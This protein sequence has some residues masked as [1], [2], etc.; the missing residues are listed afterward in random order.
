MSKVSELELGEQA[1]TKVERE[2]ND[3]NA[4]ILTRIIRGGQKALQAAVE[5]GVAAGRFG[6]EDDERLF[7]YIVKFAGKH[8]EPPTMETVN[9]KF[10][11]FMQGDTNEPTSVVLENWQQNYTRWST[12]TYMKQH[13]LPALDRG[14]APAELAEIMQR[15]AD[16]LRSLGQM[17]G[18]AEFIHGTEVEAE[19][20]RWLW[21][22]WIP[23]KS[24]TV[25]AA[26]PKVGKGFWTVWVAAQLTRGWRGWEKRNVGFLGHEDSR[27]ILKARLEASGADPAR[28]GFLRGRDNAVLT[29]PKDADTIRHQIEEHE[30]G[31]LFIDPI[32]NH[33]DDDINEN[34]DKEL[35]R[36][37]S[38]LALIAQETGCI[39]IVVHHFN[40]GS[41]NSKLL[42]RYSGAMAISGVSRS[43]LALGRKE[44]DASKDASKDPDGPEEIENESHVRWLFQTG[45]NYYA[46]QDPIRFEI[47]TREVDVKD[48]TDNVGAFV[49]VGE[50][51]DIL[52]TDCFSNGSSGGRG[53]PKDEAV[54]EWISE[55]LDGLDEA[56]PSRMQDAA[57]AAGYGSQ[58]RT[59]RHVVTEE[60]EWESERLEG[61]GRNAFVWKRPPENPFLK[62]SPAPLDRTNRPSQL[63]EEAAAIEEEERRQKSPFD[64]GQSS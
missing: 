43:V 48:G 49:Y 14:A 18:R 16:E 42:Y 4:L 8:G 2:T 45:S 3:N 17:N 40:K 28:Y 30:L 6:V 5:G 29:L 24:L 63:E 47:E 56:T 52:E 61:Q 58:W 44:K 64:K 41:I 32:N 53:Q 27:E 1:A 59:I 23:L 55:Y 33:T 50:D 60:L 15:K 54:R 34:R 12:G 51:S 37:L 35:R 39:I 19:A 25:I 13:Y 46:D 10:P 21:P 22:G 26:D 7:A 11:K 9:K 57:E 62:A 31:A 20:V 36:A 38:P